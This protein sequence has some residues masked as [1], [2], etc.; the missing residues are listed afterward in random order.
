MSLLAAGSFAS[1]LDA[2]NLETI[3]SAEISAQLAVAIDESPYVLDCSSCQGDVDSDGMVDANDLLQV[4]SDWGM[5][6]SPADLNE[7]GLVDASDL[8]E[9]I[10]GW[11]PCG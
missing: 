8:L 9:V 5:T 7:D 6:D 10:A 3:D 4:I 11:G 1:V 2:R